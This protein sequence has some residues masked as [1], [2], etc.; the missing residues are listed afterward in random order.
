MNNGPEIG[1]TNMVLELGV[2]VIRKVNNLFK[3]LCCHTVDFTGITE[4]VD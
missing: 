1:Y 3:R 4:L 2:G